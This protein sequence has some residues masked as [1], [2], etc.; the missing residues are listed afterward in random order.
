[1]NLNLVI[2]YSRVIWLGVGDGIW[3]LPKGGVMEEGWLEDSFGILECYRPFEY[4]MQCNSKIT[5]EF[6]FLLKLNAVKLP[7]C[8]RC[9][10]SAILQ[11]VFQVHKDRIAKVYLICS[12]IQMWLLCSSFY[13]YLYQ[14]PYRRSAFFSVSD[15]NNH[16]YLSMICS[17]FPGSS[18]TD[19]WLFIFMIWQWYASVPNINSYFFI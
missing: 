8:N 12:H 18:W 15:I 9:C 2:K 7:L 5:K 13:C 6:V 4:L 11:I 10:Y 17:R 19:I 1:M 14:L 16:S 3:N